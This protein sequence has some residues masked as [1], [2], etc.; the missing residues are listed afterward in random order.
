MVRRSTE[1]WLWALRRAMPVNAYAATLIEAPV[2]AA[3]ISTT[4]KP[5]ASLSL[6]RHRKALALALP[7]Q[8]FASVTGQGM[9]P[10]PLTGALGFAGLELNAT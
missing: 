8:L 9:L 3:R 5:L 10:L 7:A 1:S 4:I 6:W 2:M